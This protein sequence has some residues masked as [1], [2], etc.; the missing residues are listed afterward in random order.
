MHNGE[1]PCTLLDTMP[2]ITPLKKAVLD[3]T[4]CLIFNQIFVWACIDLNEFEWFQYIS[5][6]IDTSIKVRDI[7][8]TQ[9][10]II[11]HYVA[12]TLEILLGSDATFW[13]EF[14]DKNEA[15]VDKDVFLKVLEFDKDYSLGLLFSLAKLNEVDQDIVLSICNDILFNENLNIKNAPRIIKFRLS[16]RLLACQFPDSS[17][18]FY[19]ASIALGLIDCSK[20]KK[21]TLNSKK[22]VDTGE[23]LLRVCL[24]IEFNIL[25][26]SWQL[27]SREKNTKSI[28][29]PVPKPSIS[30]E[31]KKE[32]ADYYKDKVDNIFFNSGD[33]HF[34]TFK[35]CDKNNTSYLSQFLVYS[36]K[37]IK[38]PRI[39]TG[40]QG[41]L[42]G[43]IGASFIEMSIYHHIRN[44]ISFSI[45]SESDNT[46]TISDKIMHL[47]KRYGFTTSS[48]SL[49]LRHKD[50]KKLTKDNIKLY[51]IALYSN[52]APITWEHPDEFFLNIF[53]YKNGTL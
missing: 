20:Y 44:N 39:F 36:D 21:D 52:P 46:E 30:N 33:L 47:L 34:L 11:K 28:K 40:T 2:R 41:K 1:I 22:E 32:L 3:Q 45:Y 53:R 49:Y 19:Q 5:S 8:S 48:R 16:D 17:I 31:R 26:T 37:F 51:T 35:V 14:L 18:L 29:I 43:N 7:D 13:N 9:A 50:Y 4:D 6:S 12:C 42:I 15:P 23:L 24:L 27:S 10:P 38:Y 25:R